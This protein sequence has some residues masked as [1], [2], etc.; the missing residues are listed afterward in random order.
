MSEYELQMDIKR[1]MRLM[2]ENEEKVGARFPDGFC[3]T[4][5]GD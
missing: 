3:C 2:L 4:V 5:A 1:R